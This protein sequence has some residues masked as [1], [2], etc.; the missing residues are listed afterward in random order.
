MPA[1]WRI[2]IPPPPSPET[3]VSTSLAPVS[4][5]RMPHLRDGKKH[6]SLKL[7]FY[8]PSG[9]S[10]G[11]HSP[12]IGLGLLLDKIVKVMGRWDIK[13]LTKDLTRKRIYIVDTYCCLHFPSTIQE[14]KCDWIISGGKKCSAFTYLLLSLKAEFWDTYFATNFIFLT[15]SKDDMQLEENE[16]K[17]YLLMEGLWI[18]FPLVEFTGSSFPLLE[19]KLIWNNYSFL[20]HRL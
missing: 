11:T 16:I 13:L 14:I 17:T 2:N 4:S 5:K 15:L 20:F 12:R 7:S 1:I 9:V 10:C 18:N 8:C 6:G 19:V 3:S